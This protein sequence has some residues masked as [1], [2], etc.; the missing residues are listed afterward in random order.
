MNVLILHRDPDFEP[1]NEEPIS[2]IPVMKVIKELRDDLSYKVVKPKIDELFSAGSV[3]IDVPEEPCEQQ[4]KR[5]EAAGIY[6]TI[7]RIDEQARSSLH[8]AAYIAINNHRYD[9]AMDLLD[10]L[11]KHF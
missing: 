6:L 2:K 3:R 7:H 11:K 1:R 5:L 9:L 8:D 10:T 4:V